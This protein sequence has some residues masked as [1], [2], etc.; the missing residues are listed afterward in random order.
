MR[1][2]KFLTVGVL[3]L[4]L[5]ACNEKK[6]TEKALESTDKPAV[7]TAVTTKANLFGSWELIA[8]HTQETA[9]KKLEELFPGKK[10]MLSFEGNLMVHGND[11]CNALTGTYEVKENNGISIGDKLGATRMFCEGVADAAFTKGLTEVTNY[12]ITESALLFK[13]GDKVVMEFKQIHPDIEQ[14]VK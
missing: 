7:E 3:V 2:I 13:N 10:P 14:E 6:T 9:D 1:K 12:E 4:A 5:A 8:I 11:G